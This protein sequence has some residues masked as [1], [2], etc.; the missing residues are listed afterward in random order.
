MDVVK[1]VVTKLARLLA[2]VL[3]VSFLTFSLT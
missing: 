3:I 2:V 1:S